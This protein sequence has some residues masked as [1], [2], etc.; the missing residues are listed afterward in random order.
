MKK[1]MLIVALSGAGL[2]AVGCGG[3]AKVIDQDQSI[4]TVDQ[5]DVQDFRARGRHPDARDARF[6]AFHRERSA[7]EHGPIA[8]R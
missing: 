5:I 7:P 3:G 1:L 6:A 8:C 2:L 4:T